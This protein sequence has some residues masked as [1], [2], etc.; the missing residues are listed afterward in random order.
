MMAKNSVSQSYCYFVFIIIRK[1]ITLIRNF[2]FI[3]NIYDVICN[4]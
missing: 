3:Y 4:F 2:Y 1:N